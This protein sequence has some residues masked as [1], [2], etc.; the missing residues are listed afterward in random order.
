MVAESLAAAGVAP[1]DLSA[2]AATSGPGLASSL[3]V[4]ASFAKGMAAALGKPFLA[5]DHLEGHLLSPWFGAGEIRPNVSLLV[6]GGH[7][8]LV[9][10]RGFG[11]YRL[12]GR[13]LDDAAGEAFDKVA[14]LLGLGYPGGVR[15]EELAAAGDAGRYDFPRGMMA[16][17]DLDFS[18]SGL[19]TAMRVF[20]EKGEDWR[21]EDVCASFQEAVIEVLVHKTLR[22]ARGAGVRCITVSGGVSANRALRARFETACAS[23]G[24]DLFCAPPDLRT[25]NAGMIAFAAAGQLASGASS[26]LDAD[27]RPNIDASRFA[28]LAF[29]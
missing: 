14:K 29:A 17:G 21:M 27:I 26:P 16:S 23:S 7:T 9:E 22:A 25:D 5:V 4:G 20:L 6:S 13:T 24:L 1:R 11:R 28:G 8:L 19:K 3:L 2:V 15:I 10:V 12:L 18:F